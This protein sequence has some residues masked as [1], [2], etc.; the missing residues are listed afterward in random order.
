MRSSILDVRN[1]IPQR[2]VKTGEL[3]DPALLLSFDF[4]S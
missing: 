2:G 3:I 4:S 1:A